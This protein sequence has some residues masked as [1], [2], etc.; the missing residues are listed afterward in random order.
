[1]TWHLRDIDTGQDHGPASYDVMH[2]WCSA[3]PLPMVGRGIAKSW[4]DA[5]WF[6]ELY[7][8]SGETLDELAARMAR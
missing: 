1:M 5:E 7:S 6:A 2:E 4:P 3:A 8:D